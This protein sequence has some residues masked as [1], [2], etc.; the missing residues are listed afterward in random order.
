VKKDDVKISLTDN[1]LTLRGEKKNEV[2]NEKDNWHTVERNYGMFERRF[3]LGTPVNGEKIAAKYADGI[4]TVTMPKVEEARP[5]EI[6]I[7]F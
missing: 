2:R 1:V 4:L 7:D 6:K 5:R 3:Q